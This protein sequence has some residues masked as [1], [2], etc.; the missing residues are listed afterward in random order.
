MRQRLAKFRRDALGF[1]ARLIADRRG[2]LATMAGILLPAGIVVGAAAIDLSSVYSDR[3][4]MQQAAD[5]TAL[6][7]AKQLTVANVSGIDDRA[8]A[9]V[10]DELTDVAKRVTLT[11][12]VK[13]PT[14]NS[15][16]TITVDGSRPSFFANLLPPGGFKMHAQA[17]AEPLG[18]MPLCVLSAAG[19]GA[20]LR[21]DDS[22]QMTANGCLVQSNSDVSVTNSGL[23][24][25]GT[26]QAVGKAE[27]RITPAPQ[28]DA[29]AIPDPFASMTISPPPGCQL[30]D[31]VYDVGIQ[32]L[33]PGVHCGKI[34]VQKGATAVM[35]PGEHYFINGKLE[36][37]DSATL[38]GDDV[39]LVFDDNSSMKFGDDSKIDLGGR[40]TG[41]FA[42]FV[43][44]TTKANTNTFEISSDSARKLLGTIYIPSAQLH[45]SGIG[46]RVADQSA[47]TVIVAKGVQIGGTANL[48]IN[49]DYAGSPVP[50]PQGVGPAT[51]V[52]LTQ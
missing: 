51:G 27:G 30:L 31:L 38:Q 29:Q 49:H 47:W 28:T 12:T 48:V 52:R 2:G 20:A 35:L 7:M 9:M 37:K 25:A 1:A 21:L 39:A 41:K 8:R 4:A 34:T 43:I 22:S 40:K 36:L 26:V 24:Q 42:G 23:L 15:S 5:A 11:T 16:V 3:G 17:T 32:L 19:N 44:A 45:V 10:A 14:D 46:T 50:V 33:S 13:I 18:Q 6:A